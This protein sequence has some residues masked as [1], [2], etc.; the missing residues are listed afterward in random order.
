MAQDLTHLNAPQREAVVHGRAPLLVLAGAGTG[1]TAVIT[2][3]IAHFVG[4][5]GVPLQSILAV[6]FTNKAAKQMRER[7]G[8][9]LGVPPTAL[10]M[11]TFHRLCGRLL[12]QH[13]PR[14]GLDKNFVIY[15][16]DDQ[17]G[18]IRRCCKELQIDP[19]AFAPRALRARLETWKNAGKTPDQA[20]APLTDLVARRA[21]ALYPLY[22]RRCLEANALDFSDMLLGAVVLLRDH[23]DV[24][25]MA[26][27]R[28]S[29]ILVDEYQDTNP[30]QYAWL[31]LLVTPNHSL[32]VVGDDDQSI[33]RWRGAD[34]G[35]IL[36]FERDF[37]GATVIRLEQNYRSTNTILE[38][39]NSVIDHNV[40]RKGKTLFSERG[41]GAKIA[42]QIFDTERDE[43][44]QVAAQLCDII[45]RGTAPCDIALLYRTNAQSRPLEDALRRRHIPYQMLGG[46]RFYDRREVKD[47]LAYLRLLANPKS[48]LDLL[49][50]INVPA[51]AI[52]KTSID[53]VSQ[54]SQANNVSLLEAAAAITGA[55]SAVSE[56]LRGRAQASLQQLV[57]TLASLRQEMLAGAPL[58]E[59][60][61]H[62]LQATGYLAALAAENSEESQERL[63]NLQELAAAL[64]EYAALDEAPTLAGFLEEVS[65]SSETDN[66]AEGGGQVVMMTLHGAK[67]LEF[68][69][70]FLPGLEEGLFPHSRC[71]ED[72]A[73][74]E[75]ERRL[76]YVGLTRAKT[77]LYL[78]AARVRSIFGQPQLSEISRFVAEIPQ[79]LLEV[80]Q[81]SNRRF[82][83]H[84]IYGAAG[85]GEVAP[86]DWDDGSLAPPARPEP[87]PWVARSIAPTPAAEAPLG[88][89]RHLGDGAFCVGKRVLHATFGEG[90]VV[91]AD[92]HGP[93][94]KL[95]VEFATLGRKVIVARFVEPVSDGLQ[96]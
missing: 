88:R 78:S 3:R 9:L 16:A 85:G 13:A 32:T 39:A 95:T 23:S 18:L 42:L 19:V 54:N 45:A 47:A 35:N 60:L 74:L 8:H 65:L 94:Q 40:S 20:Q 67:G 31:K 87:Q 69:H 43:G 56:R 1:K 17:L 58:G 55:Q 28:W 48:T 75:E 33:Y 49:R 6:T 70:V 89:V 34:I 5:R 62:T 93:R 26:Q 2:H 83:P 24:R 84:G 4:E 80:T 15:D 37:P 61:G 96:G 71:L 73:A 51:R 21:L 81:A 14:L 50:I 77:N 66:L 10:D 30:V 91:A 86:A 22:Q 52:G 92:G 79:A 82:S 63:Q 46:T 41:V 90:C 57:A 36:R 25:A 72:R 44:M 11:G 59:L 7:A 64:D 53:K 27:A 68:P 12:R 76:C 38:A 29:H